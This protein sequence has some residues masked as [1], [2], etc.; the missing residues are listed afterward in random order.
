[1][2]ND[3]QQV[4]KKYK[5]LSLKLM[6][7]VPFALVIW[8]AVF[9]Y[10]LN[11]LGGVVFILGCIAT[12]I[13]FRFYWSGLKQEIV[14]PACGSNIYEWLNNEYCDYKACPHCGVSY[15]K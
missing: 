6:A 14:C 3:F 15:E 11:S 12:L 1:M 9:V 4:L 8:F 7:L 5:R 10:I 2:Q 13:F